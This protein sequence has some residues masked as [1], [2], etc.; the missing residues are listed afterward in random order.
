MGVSDE[1]LWMLHQMRSTAG[2]IDRLKLLARGWRTV[3]DLS[4]DDR[5]QLARE[6]GFDGAEELIEQLAHHGGMSPSNLLSILHRAEQADPAAALDSVRGLL[7]PGRR[8]AAAGELLDAMSDVL[9]EEGDELAEQV[10]ADQ[11]T[12]G[13]SAV[14]PPSTSEADA[15]AESEPTPVDEPA[16][17]GGPSLPP[18][19]EP[20]ATSVRDDLRSGIARPRLRPSPPRRQPVGP[21]TRAVRVAP[22]AVLAG[23]RAEPQPER[24]E[25]MAGQPPERPGDLVAELASEASLV[26]RLRRLAAATERLEGAGGQQLAAVLDCFPA[27]WARRRSLQR[28]LEAGIPESL[29][30]AVELLGMLERPSERL[31]AITT[32]A[33]T[34]PLDGDEL[35]TLIAAV[36]SPAL[37]QRLARRFGRQ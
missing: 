34:R 33:A 4:Q 25:P 35:E 24:A 28:L 3:R 19:V 10:T 8:G 16:S 9:A 18:A 7:D 37:R 12:E 20:P 36:Q 27:G 22:A 1:L 2:P 14:E 13:S 26:R 11:S 30:D 5:R 29:A 23:D 17:G 6:L 21:D 31:W 32:L 15:S